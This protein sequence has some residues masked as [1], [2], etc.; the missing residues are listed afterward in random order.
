MPI[1]TNFG[2]KALTVAT[3]VLALAVPTGS[4]AQARQAADQGPAT[5]QLAQAAD[6][7]TPTGFFALPDVTK[8]GIGCLATAGAA[9]SYAT[10]V[11]GAAETLMVAAGGLTVASTS[12]RLWLGL[13][14]T[15][16]AGSC[17]L[18]AAAEPPIE[19][20]I[21]QKD[22][23]A[24]NIAYQIEVAKTEVAAMFSKSYAADD[25]VQVTERV[26]ALR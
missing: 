16:V 20:A 21:E 2:I 4:W 13:T 25:H 7:T 1:M 9:I 6:E 14:S 8:Q 19:W 22:T 5:V 18:G 15:L 3:A 17:G 11:A 23:I 24:A 12:P 10:F 26:G